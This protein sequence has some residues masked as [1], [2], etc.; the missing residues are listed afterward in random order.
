MAMTMKLTMITI[1]ALEPQPL[2]QW[3]VDALG[4]TIVAENGGYF[5]VISLG[6][7]A[8][9]LA[10]QAVPDPT[11]GK[12]RIHLDLSA[13]DPEAEVDRLLVAGATLVARQEM[14]GFG[15]TILADP[16]GNQF[17]VAGQH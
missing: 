10:F 17:C 3:W 13:E 7:G 5:V 14:E 16:A 4:A 12:N 6:D 8:P 9:N 11:P 15:W 2:A 1:D